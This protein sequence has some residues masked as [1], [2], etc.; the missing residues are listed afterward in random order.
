MARPDARAGG[1]RVLDADAWTR[2]DAAFDGRVG[3]GRWRASRAL[4]DRW[5]ILHGGAK[6]LVGCSPSGHTGLFP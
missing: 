6:F 5:P 4:P 1:P 3:G 2:A